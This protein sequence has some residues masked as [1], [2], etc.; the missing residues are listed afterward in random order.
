MCGIAGFVD[1]SGSATRE[2]LFADV[3]RM[4][5]ALTHRGPDDA[6][7]WVDV[8]AGIA[9]GHRR[10]S[11]LD[12]SPAGHQPMASACGRY[13]I[14]FNGE[15]YNFA[16]LRAE[17]TAHGCK[18][19]GHSDTEV[20]VNAVMQWGIPSTLKRCVGMFA[21]A[22]WDGKERQLHL[23][24]DRLGEKPL[25]YGWVKDRFVFASELKAFRELPG[26][27]T[28][29]DRGAVCLL[30]R[31]GYIPAPHSIY[32]HAHKLPPG[33]F[34][35]VGE[36]AYSRD[37]L[38]A[39]TRYWSVQDAARAGI[40]RPVTDVASAVEELDRLLGEAVSLQMVA[41]VPVGAFLS[42]GIDSSTV[43]ALMQ[44][45]SPRPVRTFT[46]G[47]REAAYNEA[48]YAK[49]IAQ[50]IG[51]EHTEIYVTPEDT[52]QHI[53]ALAT[54]YDEP[55]A[56]PSQ[57]PTLLLSALV[58]RHVTVCLTGD[59]GDELFGG[60]NRY[61]WSQRLW[62][63]FRRV[64][65]PARGLLGSGIETVPAAWWNAL[66]R[67]GGHLLPAAARGPQSTAADKLRKIADVFGSPGFPDLYRSL[68]SYWKEPAALVLGAAEP[69]AGFRR[70][71]TPSPDLAQQMFCW[72]QCFYLPDDN[73]VKV[74]RASMSV[75]L[76][77]RIPLLDHRLVEFSWRVPV[78]MKYRESV[79]KW[80]LRQVLYRYVP[81]TMMERPKMGFSV[82]L[83]DWL[84]GQLRDWSESLLDEATL[85]RQGLLDVTLVRRAWKE[86]QSGARNLH[87]QLWPILMLQ[88]W[89]GQWC[90]GGGT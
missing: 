63:V 64:P 51:T 89:L 40:D 90:P 19:R 43:V 17:L 9:L 5:D 88:A 7:Y 68:V 87:G 33:T 52:L 35:T 28:D 69:D 29:I 16:T 46:I 56:D 6:G 2:A 47:F 48:A 24:R 70:F 18:F 86:H 55:F 11:I 78:Y 59:A 54:V 60:Y 79:G 61:W 84:R 39:P 42:A 53:P 14:S 80:L 71:E 25:Y 74:D 15:I 20:L 73:L 72:D 57:L 37:G 81:T 22:I 76:E 38:R 10:L 30:M 21:F 41:D 27:Q 12:L 67:A 82:P 4:T 1:L 34:L 32:R 31:L 44:R 13:Q 77:T 50:H 75:S 66:F 49:S 45:Y 83:A 23:A 85:R 62:S 3:Q 8:A 65:A 58:R 26:W 36:A